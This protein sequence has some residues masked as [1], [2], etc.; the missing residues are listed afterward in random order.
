M[1]ACVLHTA[2]DPHAGSGLTAAYAG[3]LWSLQ[4]RRGGRR[5]QEEDLRR[6]QEEDPVRDQTCTN[7]QEEAGRA[8]AGAEA[9]PRN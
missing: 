6:C 8:R 7:C 4:H 2:A 5:F 9:V 3:G 1:L